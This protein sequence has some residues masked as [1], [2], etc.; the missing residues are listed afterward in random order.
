MRRGR[1]GEVLSPHGSDFDF[2]FGIWNTRLSRLVRPL[3]GSKDWVEYEGTTV[4]REVWGGGANLV[5]LIVDGPAGHI[6]A[7]SLRLWNPNSG[8]WSLNFASR[9]TGV[10]TPPVVGGFSDGRGEFHG[11]E[12]LDGRLISVRFVISDITPISCRFE[13]F[14][15]RNAGKS[16]ELNWIATDTRVST[17]DA[18]RQP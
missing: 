15:S 2:E 13:Q 18:L 9:A 17:G 3:T 6:E 12:V 16:W 10:M 5:E 4:V 8:Q 11:Q 7:L 1:G 14:F